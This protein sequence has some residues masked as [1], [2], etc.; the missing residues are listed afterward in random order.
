LKAL[1]FAEA[2][3]EN[4]GIVLRKQQDKLRNR[5][6]A[7]MKAEGIDY[8]ERQEKLEKITYPT[9]D[10]EVIEQAFEAFAELHPWVAGF[11]P[12][13]KS[14]ARDMYE[15][16]ASFN[17]YIREFQLERSE[18]VLLRH[19]SQTYKT[20]RQNIPENLKNDEVHEML[21]YLREVITRAD[22][23]LIQAW[24]HM[25]DGT[26]ADE[27]TEAVPERL[28]ADPKRF[29]ARVRAELR[30][31]VGALAANEL[32]TVLTLL[33]QP[34][35]DPWTEQGLREAL[36]DYYADYDRIVFD[37]RSRA[38][39]LTQI[40]R[41]SPGLY[42]VTQVLCDPEGDNVWFLGGTVDVRDPT[43]YGPDTRL[44]VLE[45]IGA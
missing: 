4:P 10:A 22:S 19:L 35:A 6:Y 9:P 24:E 43:L 7:A 5:A 17:D 44:F 12:K 16:Y 15:K 21:A 37:H 8:E 36:E 33:R 32:E 26:T 42:E 39:D 25:R 38:S 30:A 27:V 40:K 31:I 29:R 11:E 28:D 41:I 23:S 34:N 14:V 18:G 3:L 2:I 20:V 13:P 45:E 1:S